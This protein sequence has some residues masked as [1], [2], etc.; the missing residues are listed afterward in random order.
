[1]PSPQEAIW[2]SS[3]RNMY[4]NFLWNRPCVK[5]WKVYSH[6]PIFSF[7][8][9]PFLLKWICVYSAD[10]VTLRLTS[11]AA[12]RLPHCCNS[13]WTLLSVELQFSYLSL[14]LIP[15]GV[16]FF[17]S[18]TPTKLYIFIFWALGFFTQQGS[19]GEFLSLDKPNLP[20][21]LC[22]DSKERSF[23]LIV[24]CGV[25]LCFLPHTVLS[26]RQ[27]S[28][29][30]CDCCPEGECP[31]LPPWYCLLFSKHCSCTYMLS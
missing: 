4:V 10:W 27:P 19:E 13:D 3:K 11:S 7:L 23:L 5:L 12:G 25:R 21:L 8:S 9:F 6:S 30:L 15:L 31:F 18:F 1:M 26:G 29:R 14:F 20:S 16:Y 17:A 28:T 22:C 24:P 2:E